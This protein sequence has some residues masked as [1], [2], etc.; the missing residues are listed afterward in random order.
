MNIHCWGSRGQIPVSGLEYNKYGGDTTCIEIRS[1]Q[2]EVIVIDAGSGI[3][4]LGYKLIKLKC[5]KI[6]LLFTHL[7]LDHIMGLPFFLP[8]YD[9]EFTIKIYGCGF[10]AGSFQNALGGIMH[11]PYFPV[12]LKDVPSKLHFNEIGT[13]S[14][15]I[16]AVKIKP[17]LLNHP[18]GGLGFRFE[19]EGKS[20]VFLTDNELGAD[21]PD[22][23]PF[24]RYIKFC[25][26]A[27]L[28][29]HDAEFDS[30]EYARYKS[31]GHSTY[32]EAVRLAFEAHVKKLG[33][34]HINNRRTDGQIESMVRAAK[35]IIRNSGKKLDCCAVGSGFSVLL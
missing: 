8:L 27:D 12:D 9:H 11:S 26:G 24:S 33:L 13:R 29:I 25:E 35:V 4:N 22:S 1:S 20:F 19:D 14:F 6:N 34:F 17:I 16:G 2:D 23:L 30:N 21:S 10:D 18:N 15:R 5:R 28:L 31:W 32:N 7:H 3:R